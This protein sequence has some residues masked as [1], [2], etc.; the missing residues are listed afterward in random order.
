MSARQKLYISWQGHRAT[1][2]S[3]QPP[4]VLVAQLLDYLQAGWQGAPEPRQQPLQAFS[5]S[6]FLQDSPL[7]T[8]ASDWARVHEQ[9]QPQTAQASTAPNPPHTA[10]AA[11]T[12]LTLADLRQLLRQPVEVFFKSRLR[13]RLDTLEELEQTEEPFALEWP[14]AVPGGPGAC[15]MPLTWLRRWNS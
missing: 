8:Y 14:G 5:E 4:S 3:E 1:D 10:L 2:N 6:Y 9:P 13:V 7:A 12:S 15:S 11:P